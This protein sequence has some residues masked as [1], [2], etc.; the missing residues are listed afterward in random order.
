MKISLNWLQDYVKL[1]APVEEICR[2]VTFLGF[3][4][5]QVLR[6]GAPR[7]EQVVVGEVLVRDKH[8]NADKLSVCQVDVGPAGGVKTIVCGAQ[9]YK[10]GD[11][12]PVALAGAVLPGNFTIKRSKIRGQESDGMMCSAKELGVA[13]DADGLLILTGRPE[14]GTPINQVLPRGD[15]VLD[16]EITPNRPDCLCHLGIGRELAAWFKQPFQYP[17]EKFRGNQIGRAHV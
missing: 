5:E 17:Q 15:V 10:V 9:N 11:R 14:L 13:E 4:V 7:L 6:T 3:E 1:D 16:I 2:A 8:P 12:V